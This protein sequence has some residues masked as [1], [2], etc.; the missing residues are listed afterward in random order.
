MRIGVSG[1]ISNVKAGH[2]LMKNADIK[3]RTPPWGVSRV[4]INKEITTMAKRCSPQQTVGSISALNPSTCCSKH[5]EFSVLFCAV[6]LCRD[7][8]RVTSLSFLLMRFA[9]Q[10][11][12]PATE[13]ITIKPL[14]RRVTDLKLFADA[15]MIFEMMAMG[16][17]VVIPLKDYGFS[18]VFCFIFP[19]IKRPIRLSPVFG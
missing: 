1:I 10:K 19:Y 3:H 15:V 9:N 7:S 11:R 12:G 13:I 4:N 16:F 6:P 8:G 14:S 2:Q 5:A 18:V 17:S